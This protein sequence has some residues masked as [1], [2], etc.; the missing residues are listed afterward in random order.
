MRAICSEFLVKEEKPPKYKFIF[1]YLLVLFSPK[2]YWGLKRLNKGSKDVLNEK[3][4][5][6]AVSGQN[7][8]AKM[9]VR[10]VT[11]VHLAGNVPSLLHPRLRHS[12]SQT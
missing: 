7:E 3:A 11:S 5:Q 4:G 2:S 8:E 6:V 10:G 12:H 1:S 9:R